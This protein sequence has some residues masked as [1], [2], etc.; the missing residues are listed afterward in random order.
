MAGRRAEVGRDMSGR[1]RGHLQRTWRKAAAQ[2]AQ[3]QGRARRR[4]Q[5][6]CRARLVVPGCS[7]GWLRC[8]HVLP[9]FQP[10]GRS[11]GRLL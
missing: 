11:S 9:A 1:G 5:P 4:A 3:A 6:L 10:G 2:P 7:A 8:C